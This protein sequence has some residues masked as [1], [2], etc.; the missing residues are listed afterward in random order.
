MELSLAE[1]LTGLFSLIFVII[2]IF[3]G[4]KIARKYSEHKKIE[5]LLVGITWIGI[6]FPWVPSA[7]TFLLVIFTDTLL[8]TEIRFILGFGLIPVFLVIWIAAFTEITYKEIQKKLLIIAIVVCTTLQVTF[9][10]LIFIDNTLIGVQVGLFHG[11]FTLF[12]RIYLLSILLTFFITGI[13]FARKS[14][15]LGDPVIKLRGKFLFVAFTFYTAGAILETLLPF[16][17]FTAVFIRLIMILSAFAFYFGFILPEI[18]KKFLIKETKVD[19]I[20]S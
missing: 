13:V 6:V 20:S 4:L 17:A 18:I 9:L 16:T 5:F 2:S 10:A 7:I 8:S 15:R 12:T 14:M 11:S 1:F 3:V 19:E